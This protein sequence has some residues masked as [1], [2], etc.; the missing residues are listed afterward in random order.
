MSSGSALQSCLSAES[1]ARNPHER[2]RHARAVPQGAVRSRQTQRSCAAAMPRKAGGSRRACMLGLTSARD[3]RMTSAKLRR[4]SVGIE[5]GERDAGARGGRAIGAMFLAVFGAAWL[6]ASELMRPHPQY[7]IIAA[8]IALAA[9]LMTVACRSFRACKR[10][11]GATPESPERLRMRHA[12]GIINGIQWGAIAVS[13]IALAAL[14]LPAWIVPS[15]MFIVGAHFLPLARITRSRPDL[16]TGLMI[17]A[18]A[19]IYPFVAQLGP[20]DP[21][22]CFA[23]GII[24]WLSTILALM[25]RSRPM[26]A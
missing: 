24:F 25:P 17:V 8:V 12:F 23:T 22:G 9:L 19:I 20:R 13:A 6:I 15:I 11:I 21:I 16:I 5:T 18:I 2:Q 10:L 4:I 1:N 14:N 3:L 26:I 7:W